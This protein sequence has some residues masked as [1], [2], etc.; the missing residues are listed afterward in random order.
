MEN[1]KFKK[2]SKCGTWIS[3]E[4]FI[5]S[6]KIVPI[7]ITFADEYYEI[8]LYYFNH[9]IE[10]CDTTLTIPVTH[11]EDEI[12]EEIPDTKLTGTDQCRNLCTDIDKHAP[13]DQRCRFAPYRRFL[14]IMMKNKGL[15]AESLKTV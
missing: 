2:C 11:F 15:H 8:S 6:A 13:C 1:A 4:E 9:A 3:K 7:G 14:L 12:K 5:S 10:G